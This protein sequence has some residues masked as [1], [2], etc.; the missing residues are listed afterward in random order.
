[1]IDIYIGGIKMNW[2]KTL[3]ERKLKIT[4]ARVTILEILDISHRSLSA[5]EV[6]KGCKDSGENINL[7]TVYRTLEVLLENNIISKYNTGEGYDKFSLS[8]NTHKHRVECS[9]CKDEI[10][11]PCPMIQLQETLKIQMDFTLTEHTLSM[12]G[13]CS[14]CKKDQ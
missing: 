14:K 11:I 1:M 12:K 7:S 13:I 6:Y 8:K 3:K 10:E 9:V 5:E 2:E 4:R